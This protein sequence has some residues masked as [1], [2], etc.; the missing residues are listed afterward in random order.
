M[1]G[2]C[3]GT[4]LIMLGFMDLRWPRVCRRSTPVLFVMLWSWFQQYHSNLQLH[5]ISQS[6]VPFNLQLC[7][8]QRGTWLCVCW[9]TAV[10][11]RTPPPPHFHQHVNRRGGGGGGGGGIDA[12]ESVHHW[13][14]SIMIIYAAFLRRV[15]EGML[16][17]DINISLKNDRQRDVYI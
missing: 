8:Y 15:I 14:I 17:I 3:W 11:C 2:D 10:S 9:S 5:E 1:R 7:W 4:W 13:L 16:F 6:V 12:S